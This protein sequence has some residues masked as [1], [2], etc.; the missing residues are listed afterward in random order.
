MKLW[1]LLPVMVAAVLAIGGSVAADSSQLT[2]VVGAGLN[3]SLQDGS[4]SRVTN[5][6]PGTRSTRRKRRSARAA[7]P[8]RLPVEVPHAP[9]GHDVA[10]VGPRHHREA[11]N[12]ALPALEV[13]VHDGDAD[14]LALLDQ[15]PRLEVAIG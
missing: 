10:I 8:R 1:L 5:L 15:P 7:L 13:A 12:R 9:G 4:G 14:R 3:I 11:R 2:G 6:A